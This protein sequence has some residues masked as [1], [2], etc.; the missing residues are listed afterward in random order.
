MNQPLP[1]LQ[2]LMELKAKVAAA[3]DGYAVALATRDPIKQIEAN[4][5]LA[6]AEEAG[7][8]ISRTAGFGDALASG[9]FGGNSS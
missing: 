7:R 5:T 1:W 6:G 9:T 8:R 2:P 4:L 3:W